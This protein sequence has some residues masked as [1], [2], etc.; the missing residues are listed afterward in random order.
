MQNQ[1]LFRSK[2]GLATTSIS[3]A[4]VGVGLVFSGLQGFI[5]TSISG[6]G[7]GIYSK[8]YVK[9]MTTRTISSFLLKSVATS[10]HAH[11][12][13]P[14]IVPPITYTTGGIGSVANIV[15]VPPITYTTGRV[16]NTVDSLTTARTN[17]REIYTGTLKSFNNLKEA[18][19]LHS[20][21]VSDLDEIE[22]IINSPV[23]IQT[24]VDTTLPVILKTLKDEAVFESANPWEINLQVIEGFTPE[25][26]DTQHAL[27]LFFKKQIIYEKSIENASTHLEQLSTKTPFET[28]NNLPLS[29]STMRQINETQKV[30]TSKHELLNFLQTKGIGP[31]QNHLE[32]LLDASIRNNLLT[33]RDSCLNSVLNANSEV[34]VATETYNLAYRAA[35]EANKI[36]KAEEIL[37]IE[38]YA[39]FHPDPAFE[40]SIGITDF[41]IESLAAYTSHPYA[42]LGLGLLVGVTC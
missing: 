18:K 22:A 38:T 2:S 36:L 28:L 27:K 17:A 12:A 19:K 41:P 32:T 5:T 25:L 33:S 35:I 15:N 20:E 11:T 3:G 21:A 23:E 14:L 10:I 29:D 6:A 42:L 31:V 37:S 1:L 26:E 39:R 30:L 9:G 34:S 40:P 13:T 7:V 8:T 24:I 4:G 16:A